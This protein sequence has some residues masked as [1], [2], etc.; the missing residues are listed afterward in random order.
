MSR[1]LENDINHLVDSIL[2][3]YEQERDI[4]IVDAFLPPDKDDIIK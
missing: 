3:D 1:R 4:D 2:T